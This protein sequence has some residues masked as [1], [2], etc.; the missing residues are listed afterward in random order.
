MQ[1]DEL[2]AAER[3]HVEDQWPDRE[4]DEATWDRGP[5]QGSVPGFRVRRVTP[6]AKGEPWVYVTLGVAQLRDEH[7]HGAEFVLL[8][9]EED[10]GNVELLAMVAHFHSDPKYRSL[11]VGRVI[12]IGRPWV[13]GAASDHLLVSPAYPFPPSFERLDLDGGGHVQFLWLVPITDAEAEYLHR[14]G[15]DA[16]EAKLEESG[17]EMADPRRTSV[18]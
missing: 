7:D 6:R 13:A 17:A 3:R 16:L 2:L 18:V 10:P 1:V 11:G 14:E 9:P 15:M 8:T 12:D 5:V 4:Q